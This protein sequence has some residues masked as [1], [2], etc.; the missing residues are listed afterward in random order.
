MA[1][2]RFRLVYQTILACGVLSHQQRIAQITSVGGNAASGT[3]VEQTSPRGSREPM[4]E[5]D[6][7]VRDH[8]VM[9]YQTTADCTTETEARIAFAR[10]LDPAI[11]D[12]AAGTSTRRSYMTF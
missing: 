6:M 2:P 1:V 10:T 8:N 4:K 9:A 5:A 11:T 7:N 3:A 12:S